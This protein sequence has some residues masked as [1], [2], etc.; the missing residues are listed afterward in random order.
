MPKLSQEMASY[1]KHSERF[2]H[3]GEMNDADKSQKNR[4]S[5]DEDEEEKLSTPLPDLD[6]LHQLSKRLKLAI[7]ASVLA[8]KK[9]KVCYLLKRRRKP[10][11]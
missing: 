4:G 1:A 3:A 6:Q 7:D 5:Q 8:R 2:D 11:K 9:Q 10:E